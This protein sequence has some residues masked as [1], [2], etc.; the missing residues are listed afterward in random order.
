MKKNFFKGDYTW[1]WPTR[2][3][4]LLL[5]DCNHNDVVLHR[6]TQIAQWDKKESSE[7]NQER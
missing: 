4:N 1:H 3:L 6:K 2:D 7:Q 5:I